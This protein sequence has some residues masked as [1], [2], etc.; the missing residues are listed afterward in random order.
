MMDGWRERKEGRKEGRARVEQLT[1]S[2]AGLVSLCLFSS[3][4]PSTHSFL[5]FPTTHPSI[6]PSPQRLIHRSKNVSR[7]LTSPLA[8]CL[9]QA[10]FPAEPF[11]TTQKMNK[12]VHPNSSLHH[13]WRLI[14]SS[15]SSSLLLPSSSSFVPPQVPQQI[16]Q[17]YYGRGPLRV[18]Q[19]RNRRL[20]VN[21]PPHPTSFVLSSF[22]SS[23]MYEWLD[24]SIH[25][26]LFFFLLLRSSHP[27]VSTR[28]AVH[29]AHW[30]PR[31]RTLI[32]GAASCAVSVDR[33]SPAMRCSVRRSRRPWVL[34]SGPSSRTA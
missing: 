9:L 8:F 14:L 3:P 6:H 16:C 18:P 20:S 21:L 2:A 25:R 32:P 10:N 27:Q 29:P 19:R 23:P 17:G 30:V 1:A 15:S 7:I 13:L 26:S 11:Q 5:A 31:L 12:A 33:C 4:S 28:S 22:S 34:R 24:G